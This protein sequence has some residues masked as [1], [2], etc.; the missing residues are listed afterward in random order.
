MIAMMASF[1]SSAI[2]GYARG[3]GARGQS[4]QRRLGRRTVG[5]RWLFLSMG[6]AAS[7]L[8]LGGHGAAVMI[9]VFLASLAG[10]VAG[11]AFSAICGAMLFHIGGDPVE[12]VQ[13]LI[14][15]SIA[16]QTAMTWAVR[17]DIDWRGMGV[18]LAGGL[19]GLSGGVWILLHADHV[20]YTQALGILLLLYG[21][22]MLLRKPVIV[23]WR[24]TGLDFAAGFL[25][26]VTGGAAA[27][28]SV[29]VTLWCGMKG[30]DKRRQRAVFQPFI[31]ILQVVAFVAIGMA[32]RPGAGI[33]GYDF[34]DLL[35]IPASL[36]GTSVGLALYKTLSD[37]QFGRAVNILLIVSGL[38]F[39]L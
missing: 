18:F 28:P 27:L 1:A 39:V 23:R 19:C 7:C 4:W 32:R 25:G 5:G 24:H 9:C 12:V 29:P 21:F 8:W 30:W 15:C 17:R 11:F 26:G 34:H 16:N 22:Y 3:D 36:L 13:V 14:T 10:S 35:F 6:C 37:G 31:L 20:R 2:S 38:S 33:I